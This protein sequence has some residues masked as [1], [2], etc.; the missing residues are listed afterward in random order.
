MRVGSVSLLLVCVLGLRAGNPRASTAFTPARSPIALPERPRACPAKRRVGLVCGT[1]ERAI[2]VRRS[3]SSGSS[4]SPDG[5]GDQRDGTPVKQRRVEEIRAGILTDWLRI[6]MLTLSAQRGS[7]SSASPLVNPQAHSLLQEQHSPQECDV[8]LV[9]DFL[10]S[11]G[12]VDGPDMRTSAEAPVEASVTFPKFEVAVKKLQLVEEYWDDA[13]DGDSRDNAIGQMFDIL[14][15]GQTEISRHRM[16]E[17]LSALNM[18]SSTQ[19]MSV[20]YGAQRA[21]ATTADVPAAQ[22]KVRTNKYA[23]FSRVE[24]SGGWPQ[25]DDQ[26][27]PRGAGEDGEGKP[28][29]DTPEGSARRATHLGRKTLGVDHGRKRTGVCVSVGYAPRPLPLI[30]HDDDAGLV[31]RRVA[32]LAEDERAQQIVVGFPF[33]STGGEGE[34]AQYTRQF[35]AELKAACPGRGIYLWDERYFYFGDLEPAVYHT[36]LPVHSCTRTRTLPHTSHTHTY[37]HIHTHTHTHDRS[38]DCKQIHL[39]CPDQPNTANIST[40]GRNVQLI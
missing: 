19:D 31:A 16:K 35:V 23:Q 18:S 3:S 36:H 39:G 8:D 38:I 37:T 6:M 13:P 22:T 7:E 34:Q 29:K 33:N 11:A 9:L 10:C 17:V 26:A 27:M 40:E 5:M 20:I 32:E 28:S 30:C 12:D 2:I 24:A 15:Q 21:A 1:P 14:S 4:S 25:E